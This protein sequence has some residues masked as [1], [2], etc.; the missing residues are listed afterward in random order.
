MTMK[1]LKHRSLVFVFAIG[2]SSPERESGSAW[3]VN[4]Q[5]TPATEE[6][7]VEVPDAPEE[8]LENITLLRSSPD[9]PHHAKVTD[10]YSDWPV[11]A[12]MCSALMIIFDL[13]FQEDVILGLPAS[14]THTSEKYAFEI[15]RGR[16]T[17]TSWLLPS[18]GGV[19]WAHLSNGFE[20]P[21]TFQLHSFP[22][23]APPMGVV[24]L[25]LCGAAPAGLIET[26]VRPPE[27]IEIEVIANGE[28]IRLQMRAE[29]QQW[30][31]GLTYIYRP[32]D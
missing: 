1:M 31:S 14:V 16:L 4:E 17:D 30:D 26:I 27:N 3:M 24:P 2:C 28:S 11:G 13:Q 6:P 12:L 8:S 21:T 20:E 23:V 15:S 25:V 7:A 32:T 9:D 19:V 5:T 22:F 18:E 10:Y 29:V